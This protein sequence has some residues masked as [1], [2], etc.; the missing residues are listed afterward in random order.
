MIKYD[1]LVMVMIRKWYVIL[2]SASN[3]YH[4]N[5]L[6][7]SDK[8][9]WENNDIIIIQF[10]LYCTQHCRLYFIENLYI[11]DNLLIHIL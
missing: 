6:D 7:R 10:Q 2:R 9:T 1:I 8:A 3:N 5:I 11:C 4:D